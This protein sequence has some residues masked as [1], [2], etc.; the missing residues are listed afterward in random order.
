MMVSYYQML[1]LMKGINCTVLLYLSGFELVTPKYNWL[2]NGWCLKNIE[3][4]HQIG[5]LMLRIHVKS[6]HIDIIGVLQSFSN[7]FFIAMLANCVVGS[8]RFCLYMSQFQPSSSMDQP[9]QGRL[10]FRR[11]FAVVWERPTLVLTASWP[12]TYLRLLQRQRNIC[13]TTR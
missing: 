1:N 3:I 2:N 8:K 5:S 13:K 10:L 9:H 7:E 11:W 6:Y 12:M 4:K